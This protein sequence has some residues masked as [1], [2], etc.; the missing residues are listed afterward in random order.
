MQS[1]QTELS[2]LCKPLTFLIQLKIKVG[3]PQK[4][5]AKRKQTRSLVQKWEPCRVVS[6]G[7]S[8]RPD[9]FPPFL[10]GARLIQSMAGGQLEGIWKK[11][12]ELG[13][14]GMSWKSVRDLG[15]ISDMRGK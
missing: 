2:A 13:E 5:K 12:S 7:C 15:V 6:Q 14:Q 11:L 8:S 1:F 10:L 9:P 3:P 4:K